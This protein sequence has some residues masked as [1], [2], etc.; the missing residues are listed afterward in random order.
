MQ[1][2]VNYLDITPISKEAKND[3]SLIANDGLHPS[4][5][6]YKRWADLLA[7]MMKQVLQ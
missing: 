5:S 7:P 3:P 4:G 6:Q 2:G 1:F